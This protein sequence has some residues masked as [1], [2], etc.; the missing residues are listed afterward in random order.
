MAASDEA[1]YDYIVVGGGSAGC[2]VAARLSEDPNTNV[3]LLEAGGQDDHIFLKMPLAFLKAMPDPRFNWT[4][5]TEPEPHLD[6]RKMPMPRGRVMGGSGSIN[7]MFAMRGH[8]KDYD[9]WAQMGARGW[10]FAEVLPYFKKMEK[11]WRGEGPY[12]GGNGPVEIRP[13]ERHAPG[14]SIP[15]TS[16]ASLPKASPGANRRSIRTAG[17]SAQRRPISN[18]PRVGGTSRSAPMLWSTRWCSKASA[19]S[20]SRSISATGRNWCARDER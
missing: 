16:V 9:Q 14:S 7:G 20:G 4:Y 10:S 8:P 19:R 2:V 11:S 18:R 1:A 15:R 13:I 6:N 12:H 3:L 17:G 5:W